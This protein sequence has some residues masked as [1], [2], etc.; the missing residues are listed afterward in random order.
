MFF[1][2]P[3]KISFSSSVILFF[4][5]PSACPCPCPPRPATVDPSSTSRTPLPGPLHAYGQPKPRLRE[6]S[7]VLSTPVSHWPHTQIRT[8]RPNVFDCLLLRS[9]VSLI[10]SPRRSSTILQCA[11]RNPHQTTKEEKHT[12]QLAVLE[13]MSRM[14][15]ALIRNVSSIQVFH[16]SLAPQFGFGWVGDRSKRLDL[17]KTFSFFSK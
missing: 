12:G 2:F 9:L 6:P 8:V 17:D 16:A 3:V 11:T 5:T 10:W 13:S 1:S 14:V 15:Q 7:Q 4:P